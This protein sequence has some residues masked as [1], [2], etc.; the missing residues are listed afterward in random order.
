[1]YQL[2]QFLES[3]PLVEHIRSPS[4]KSQFRGHYGAVSGSYGPLESYVHNAQCFH[5]LHERCASCMVYDCSDECRLYTNRIVS[6]IVSGAV[7][8]IHYNKENFR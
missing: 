8:L 6:P 7:V 4:I 1:M 5:T 3:S 2:S